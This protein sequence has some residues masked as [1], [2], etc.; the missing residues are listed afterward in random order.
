M[1]DGAA[2]WPTDHRLMAAM[3]RKQTLLDPSLFLTHQPNGEATEILHEVSSTM[4]WWKRPLLALGLSALWF[5]GLVVVGGRGYP[6]EYFW[7]S[8]SALAVGFA[9]AP[10]WRFRASAWYWPTVAFLGAAHLAAL[11]I[12]RA[13]I[14]NPTLPA[15]GVFLGLFVLDVMASW[16]VMVGVCYLLKGQFPWEMA[17]Q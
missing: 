12:E 6:S 14:S 2:K 17:D 3:G 7:L 1:M 5:C 15:K 10:F 13:Y 8:V 16:G 4:I 11:A 9:V